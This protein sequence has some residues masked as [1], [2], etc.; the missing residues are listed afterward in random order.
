[1]GQQLSLDPVN[2][3][4]QS[5]Q[6]YSHCTQWNSPQNKVTILKSSDLEHCMKGSSCIFCLI[7][8]PGLQE[9]FLL[10]SMLLVA[11]LSIWK[12]LDWSFVVSVCWVNICFYGFHSL[13]NSIAI[14]G[15]ISLLLITFVLAQLLRKKVLWELCSDFVMIDLSTLSWKFMVEMSSVLCVLSVLWYIGLQHLQWCPLSPNGYRD[16]GNERY[17]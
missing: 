16:S 5:E 9:A 2:T 3:L 8:L 1:M 17:L 6:E 11:F 15:P 12:T 4:A 13:Y 10:R 7:L 14:P